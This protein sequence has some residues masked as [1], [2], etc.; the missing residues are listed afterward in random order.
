MTANLVA[1]Q[2]T[3]TGPTDILDRMMTAGGLVLVGSDGAASTPVRRTWEYMREHYQN[4]QV[5]NSETGTD[6][7][8]FDERTAGGLVLMWPPEE[9]VTN[10]LVMDY[11]KRPADMSVVYDQETITAGV[12]NGSA[13]VTF[14]A[15]I[16]GQF[17]AGDQFGVKTSSSASPTRWYTIQSID[18]STGATLSEVYAGVTNATSMFCTS[19][20]SEI[21]TARPGL[22]RYAP[23]VYALWQALCQDDGVENQGAIAAS[24]L[25]DRELKRI[26]QEA[27]VHDDI[28]PRGEVPAVQ[29]VHAAVAAREREER[30]R[31][32]RRP[33]PKK[34]ITADDIC[35]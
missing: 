24:Q 25:W 34:V 8:C 18:S 7:W 32:E 26:N 27:N 31:E 20:I 22:V 11:V 21:D 19:E 5:L 2:S 28:E 30:E 29:V 16:T 23:T 35:F 10:G 33:Q 13:A 6:D 4:F 15:S 14:S 3:Y 1:G 9:S 17:S 12:T